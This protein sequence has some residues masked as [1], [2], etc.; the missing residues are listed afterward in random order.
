MGYS[1]AYYLHQNGLLLP[2]QRHTQDYGRMFVSLR[3]IPVT[4]QLCSTSFYRP[5]FAL[6]KWIKMGIHL[7]LSLGV[8]TYWYYYIYCIL[9]N[10]GPQ[11]LNFDQ[12][13]SQA[14]ARNLHGN[15]TSILTYSRESLLT[16]RRQ[17]LCRPDLSTLQSLKLAGLLRFRGRRAG[18]RRIPVDM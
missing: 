10:H 3:T 18:R 5:K 4:R 11:E 15:N 9:R 7:Y 6:V 1:D 17:L 16:I 14:S 12:D 8:I 2:F 13:Y